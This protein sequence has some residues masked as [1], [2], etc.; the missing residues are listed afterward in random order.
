MATKITVRIPQCSACETPFRYKGAE[1]YLLPCLHPVCADCIGAEC[2]TVQCSFCRYSFDKRTIVLPK[3][4]VTEM[5]ILSSTLKLKPSEV[6]CTNKDHGNSAKTARSWCRNCQ[7]M[8][9]RSCESA[10][11]QVKTSRTHQMLPVGDMK[12][13]GLTPPS[14][15]CTDHD[16][17]ILDL[18]DET[19]ETLICSKCVRSEHKHCVVQEL[20]DAANVGKST[21]EQRKAKLEEKLQEIRKA[22]TETKTTRENSEASYNDS[23][24]LLSNRFHHLKECLTKREAELQEELDSKHRLNLVDISRINLGLQN[25]LRKCEDT[26][27]FT[28][29]LLRYGP[30]SDILMLEKCMKIQTENCLAEDVA[31]AEVEAMQLSFT[32]K[33]MEHLEEVISSI[34]TTK[35]DIPSQDKENDKKGS[36]EKHHL[37][38]VEE[39]LYP[40]LSF[41]VERIN[42]NKVHVNNKG[43]L[44]NRKVSQERKLGQYVGTT[45]ITPLPKDKVSYWEVESDFNMASEMQQH[46]LLMEIGVARGACL[47]N[48]YCMSG[49]KGSMCLAISHCS[50]HKGVCAKIWSNGQKMRCYENVLST[51]PGISD[52]LR[53]GL[54]FDG[55]RNT[56]TIFDLNTIAELMTLDT[57]EQ[58]DDLWP[59]FGAYNS[60]LAAVQM[61][62]VSGKD[63][64]LSLW[65]NSFLERAMAFSV[66]RQ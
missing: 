9:C 41:D 45:A 14:A 56:L 64:Q 21:T 1:P 47:D 15:L 36:A 52:T 33:Q 46:G 60:C 53:H 61:K 63:I 35:S 17:Y 49:Q 43:F 58:A 24:T 4:H 28:E 7:A 59:V 34:G 26:H 10:H 37:E 31:R 39:R 40:A 20:E 11:N 3:D 18:Y 48:S 25:V 54:L 62:L 27:D 51:S 57:E 30:P 2:E 55:T 22:M 50:T 12:A 42:N 16:V 65:K 13:G 38:P 29:K 32:E 66:A 23:K 5:D 6:T 8:F 19:C 44:V